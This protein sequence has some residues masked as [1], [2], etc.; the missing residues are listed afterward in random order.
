VKNARKGMLDAWNEGADDDGEF[1]G[2]S[3]D[4]EEE[5]EEKRKKEPEIEDWW[6]QELL[7]KNLKEQREQRD[8]TGPLVDFSSSSGV[9]SVVEK[10][11][12]SSEH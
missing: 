9:G 5:Q 7:D 1:G 12:E 8:K 4:E 3:E 10:E 2:D 11:K 6:S